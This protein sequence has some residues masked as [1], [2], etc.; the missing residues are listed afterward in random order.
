M[1][2]NLPDTAEHID[3][4]AERMIP[5]TG[6]WPAASAMEIG[7]DL[8]PRLRDSESHRVE[9]ALA[10]LGPVDGFRAKSGEEQDQLLRSLEVSAPTLFAM[11]RQVIY[12]AYYAQPEV[13]ALLRQK[14]YDIQETPQ[15]NGYHMAP[16]DEE[17]APKNGRGAWIPTSAVRKRLVMEM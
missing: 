3:L 1:K 15:P 16:F 9:T 11:L 8:L 10:M 2:T 4:V 14:G 7:A 6:P 17:R 12:F 5:A 13:V